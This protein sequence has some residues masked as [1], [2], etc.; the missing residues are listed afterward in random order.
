MSLSGVSYL[1]RRRSG[2]TP[3]GRASNGLEPQVRQPMM[4]R[5][6]LQGLAFTLVLTG[7]LSACAA[8]SKCGFGCP[9][10]AD[11]TADVQALF[12]QHPALEPPNLLTIQTLDHVVYLNGLVFAP[13][14]YNPPC[15]DFP[16][17]LN[18]L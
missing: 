16:T 15:C 14:P 9:G 5:R 10:D 2:T 3:R 12:D 1:N 4:R 6:H 17:G 13:R 7:A 18:R 11:I 8:F